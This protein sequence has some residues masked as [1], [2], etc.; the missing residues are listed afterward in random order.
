MLYLVDVD[1]EI[2]GVNLSK[3]T[4]NRLAWRCMDDVAEAVDICSM[5]DVCYPIIMWVRDGI[6]W[7]REVG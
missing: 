6:R 5:R 7:V 4:A 3:L 2:M 1:G